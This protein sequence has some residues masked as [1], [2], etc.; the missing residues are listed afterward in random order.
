M[1]GERL[2]TIREKRGL[3]Q[4]ELGALCGLGDKQIWRYE[5][6]QSAPNTEALIQLARILG[7]T[8]D[9]LLGLVEQPDE[10]LTE[11][12]LSPMERKLIMAVRQGMIV[13]AL[14]AVT[15]ISKG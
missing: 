1:F 11:E 3:T 14:E 7:I 5:N 10:H 15:S 9:Y 12:T 2:R 8:S 13:E 6:G 4:R